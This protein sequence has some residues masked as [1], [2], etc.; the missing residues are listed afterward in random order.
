RGL[1]GLPGTPAAAFRAPSFGPPPGPGTGEGDGPRRA[2]RPPVMPSSTP[3]AARS[4]GP[5]APAAAPPEPVH[6]VRLAAGATKPIEVPIGSSVSTVRL[7]V[8]VDDTSPSFDVV[9]RRSGGSPVWRAARPGP[10]PR[11]PLR[12]DRP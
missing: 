4:P 5:P 11:E 10:P 8:P 6:L 9:L 12:P 3:A 7:E 2:T 1:R